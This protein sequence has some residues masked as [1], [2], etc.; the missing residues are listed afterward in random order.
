MSSI[1]AVIARSR[2]P[3]AFTE[4]QRFTLA[5]SRAI[6]KMRQFAL[7]DPHYY[8][9]EL[10]QS[11]IANGAA[12]IE[13]RADESTMIS[14]YLGGE[15]L[16]EA[17]LANLFDFL[18]ASKERTELTSL[19]ALALAV[20]ALMLF[21][22]ARIVIESGDGTLAGTARLE[23][24]G[25]Q[26]RMDVGR[27]EAPLTGTYVR[28]E[29]MQRR[30]LARSMKLNILGD[31]D[32]E[33]SI[34]EQ[35]CLTAPV[36]I[37]FNQSPVFGHARQRIPTS[38]GYQRTM[39]IDEGDLYGSLGIEP[40]GGKPSFRL[41]TYGVLVEAVEF[42]LLP[43]APLGGVINFDGL[44]KTADHARIV[45]DERLAEMWARLRPY[46]QQLQR[47]ERAE[48]AY[49]VRI[50]G[51]G[52]IPL[53]QLRTT[54]RALER[55]VVIDPET[56]PEEVPTALRIAAAMEAELL[57][58][59]V[60]QVASL[61]MLAGR[62]VT[63]LTPNLASRVDVEFY[64]RA[65]AS[66][67]ARPWL[68]SPREAP[69]I[70]AAELAEAVA[71]AI[72]A[73]GGR[74]DLLA[75]GADGAAL[76]ERGEVRVT[77]YTPVAQAAAGGLVTVRLWSLGRE[78]AAHPVMCA[79]GGHVL[80]VE[81][82]EVS[83]ARALARVHGEVTYS[84]VVARVITGKV[85]ALLEEASRRA[86]LALVGQTV[87]PGT[88]QARLALSAM[89]RSTMIRLRR[90]A[91][92]IRAALTPLR[93]LP[94][95]DLLAIPVLATLSG[96]ALDGRSLC[97]LMNACEGVLFGVIPEVTPDLEG[98]DQD[99]ILAL[100]LE[101]ERL[102]I[103]MVGEGAYVRVDGRDAL[104]EHEGLVVRDLAVGL[105][106]FPDLLLPVEGG[107][108]AALTAE[109]RATAETELFAQLLA[110]YVEAPREGHAAAEEARRQCWLHLQRALCAAV[111][112]GEAAPLGLDLVI[113]TGLD[114]QGY[115]LR[116]MLAAMREHGRLLIHYDHGGAP[117]P[118]E[119][120]RRGEAPP[121]EIRAN[122]ALAAALAR[123]GPVELAFD[124]ALPGDQRDD[125]KDMSKETDFLVHEE[126]AAGGVIGALGVLRAAPASPRILLFD[127]EG[128]LLH[129]LAE[130]AR[131]LSVSGYLQLSGEASDEGPAEA[132]L[133]EIHRVGELLLG[134]LR[135]GLAGFDA[136]GQRRAAQVLLEHVGGHL[137][138][139]AAP[140][141][142]VRLEVS[143]P[144]AA[145]IL[146]APLF[147]GRE[148][149]P[150]RGAWVLARFCEAASHGR[151]AR[152]AALIAEDAEPWLV[153]WLDAFVHSHR[154]V[155][156]PSR[157]WEAA[158]AAAT[159][160]P[161][162]RPEG[163]LSSAQLA[164]TVQRHLDRLRPDPPML[165]EARGGRTRVA[166][167]LD[168]PL[169]GPICS[170]VG[171]GASRMAITLNPWH[172]LCE[173]AREAGPGDPAALAWLLLGV[174]AEVNRALEDVT[175]EHEEA[176]QRAV[177]EALVRGELWPV[178]AADA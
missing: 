64:T 138:L 3:G 164:A 153:A 38:F 108:P 131:D 107:A 12:H 5:R 28:A 71:Q 163:A 98:L 39:A 87:T 161:A 117:P 133:A 151:A 55:V 93:Q 120:I 56:G 140:S 88:P 40:M 48:R 149:L 143:S 112:G 105:R 125:L 103:A 169:D 130:S 116:H 123:L 57:T 101:L 76:G 150:V 113:A 44:H 22:P 134:R 165:A 37:L 67:P 23:I 141:G 111:R 34:I 109:A 54:L 127:R 126:V 13:V 167:D 58:A 139:I 119:A 157:A 2:R 148:G 106:E 9:L 61:R 110:R 132:M 122:P 35:R 171:L 14:S 65:P 53:E 24:C 175:G 124:F 159:A 70:A 135:E 154:V 178:Y 69:S 6:E 160:A 19:R 166:A 99:R 47:G 145:A 51:G 43:G 174:Y 155:R 33:R 32:D 77:I 21:K 136:A 82:P 30:Q 97:E 137:S 68:L 100:D 63:M 83:P 121:L 60:G 66:P 89:V 52:A 115:S 129:A 15:G 73:G 11:A 45:Q 152:G 147:P 142:V 79:S 7:A 10:I 8:V 96:R 177:A 91:E 80:V 144:Q 36:P 85:E 92:G 75:E 59:P 16:P 42:E 172:W 31:G 50:Y 1:E 27:P 49:D 84:E 62:D 102:V 128:R 162:S 95:L 4:R 86:L 173:W 176:M 146:E 94:G 18:F 104:A 78:I 81:I 156:P 170:V 90:S 20:N 72:A 114:A 74:G 158:P 46:A 25:D 17:G 168:A 118:L 26:D 41:L 29:G